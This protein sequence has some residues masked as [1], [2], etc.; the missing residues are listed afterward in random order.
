MDWFVGLGMVLGVLAIALGT[1]SI[2]TGWTLSWARRHVARP[3]VY[4][5][6]GLLV[7]TPCTVQGLFYFGIVP[8]PSWEIRFFSMNVLLLSGLVLLGVGQ[9]RWS[10]R[11]S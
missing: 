2:R 11:R 8:S 1:V 6:G 10:P 4:G 5:L 9:M 7:G 3:R